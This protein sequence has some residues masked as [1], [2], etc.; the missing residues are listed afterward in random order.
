ME[1]SIP[2][3]LL[4]VVNVFRHSWALLSNSWIMT[5]ALCG[6]SSNIL[7]ASLV[8]NSASDESAIKESWC[9]EVNNPKVS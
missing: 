7:S 9:F 5:T 1:L 8:D 4:P 3:P 6:L 2:A